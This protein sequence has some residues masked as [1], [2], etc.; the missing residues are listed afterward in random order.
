MSP[1]LHQKKQVPNPK[2]K[3]TQM[4]NCQSVIHAHTHTHTT[5]QGIARVLIHYS[6]RKPNETKKK[7]TK[8]KQS[9]FIKQSHI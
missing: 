7:Q 8:K 9:E 1:N 5:I 4:T 3:K 2:Q 6:Q